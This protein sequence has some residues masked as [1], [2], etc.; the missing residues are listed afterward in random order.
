[1]TAQDKSRQSLLNLFSPP[2]DKRRGV[3]GL[4]CGLSADEQFMDSVL[5]QF[6]GL[7]RNQR[8]YSGHMSIA[9]F[10]DAH[11]KPIHS[12]PGLYN[13]W[14]NK[15]STWKNISLMHAKVALLGF[16]ESAK[17]KPDYY[18]LIVSTGNWTKEAVN[19]SINLVWYCDYDTVSKE[20]Q[21]QNAKDIS[22]TVTFWQQL[23]GTNKGNG[24]YY[25]IA[26]NVKK[27]IDFF[28]NVASNAI[29]PP[30]R[31]YSS[32]FI[33][34]LL[35]GKADKIAKYFEADSMGAQVLKQFCDSE[36]R[37]N[38]II[39]GSGF[40]EQA[41]PKITKANG[42]KPEPEVIHKII[43]Y[44]K[45]KIL[46]R[47]PIQWLVINPQSSGA[48]GQWIKSIEPDDL[49]WIL[50]R[51]KHPEFQK[52][53]YPFHAKYVFIAN[54]KDADSIESITSGLLYIGS[55]NLSKQGFILGPRNGG[56]IEAGVV[57]ET[58]KYD[59]IKNFCILLGIDPENILKAK[60]IPDQVDG[61]ESEQDRSE[62]QN[63][64]P[65]ASCVWNPTTSKLT[66]QWADSDWVDVTLHDQSVL[67]PNQTELLIDRK[68]CDFSSGVKLNA[69]QNGKCCEWIIPVFAENGNSCSP[70]LRP[71]SGQEIIDALYS[72]PATSYEDEDDDMDN[73]E[74]DGI[75]YNGSITQKEDFSELRDELDRFPL[76]LATSLVEAIAA[77]NQQIRE[78]QLPDW[79][80]H[81]RRILIDEMKPEIK[82]KLIALGI[83]IL[84][85]LLETAGFAPEKPNKDYKKAI[86]EII[87]NW[88]L[89]HS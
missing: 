50:G 3:F 55:G 59:S 40:F 33:S 52:T 9:L 5:E 30:Q 67:S 34:N 35:N 37:R 60:D 19:N 23:T 2:N 27:H 21:K 26:E 83:D 39:C 25:Q 71:K 69:K 4:I 44:L 42:L 63:P 56:N 70:P 89:K 17:G 22:E 85:P 65:I 46:T 11:N 57:V 77:R 72:F 76:H 58:E 66:F 41:D 62:F 15:Q 78:G 6:S 31:G 61:E 74:G 54:Y 82:K 20:D 38:F 79:I 53:P 13:P 36:I 84:N 29:I 7:N 75:I 80:E 18:R 28:L 51:P 73:D 45:N 81:F 47:D 1:M 43:G 86:Q 24:N 64:P 16:G 88:G 8:K 32:Q 87:D 10:L 68:D 14:P 12:L 48:A 49:V